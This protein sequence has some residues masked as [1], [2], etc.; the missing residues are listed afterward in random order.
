LDGYIGIIVAALILYSGFKLVKET[1]NPLLGEAPDAELV[2]KI[3]SGVMGYEHISGVHDLIIHNY[4]PGKCMA[5]IHAEVPA[6]INIVKIHDIIDAA[7]K[8]ISENLDIYL[9]IH[10]DPINVDDENVNKTKDALTVVLKK[11]PI[12]KSIHDF[13]MIGEGSHKN[14][15][16]DA[17]LDSSIRLTDSEV[18]RL[19]KDI[20]QGV[21][22]EY[23]N[24]QCNITFDK[25]F[26]HL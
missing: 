9:V 4:G 1:L 15:I 6:D 24:Y 13:R 8:E 17:V 10:M 12:V 18:E 21:K 16:F 14:L 2:E 20:C 11:F 23:P 26:T 5:S 19:K 25:D 7:E 3:K 22:D